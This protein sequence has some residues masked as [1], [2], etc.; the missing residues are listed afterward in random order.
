MGKACLMSLARSQ[1]G[2]R[3]CRVSEMIGPLY[4]PDDVQQWSPGVEIGNT[5]GPS[6]TGFSNGPYSKSQELR[7]GGWQTPVTDWVCCCR[8]VSVHSLWGFPNL[9]AGDLTWAVSAKQASSPWMEF[10]L[11]FRLLNLTKHGGPR[12]INYLC[13]KPK[14]SPWTTN[15]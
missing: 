7:G 10:L 4:L 13:K 8:Q 12:N 14:Q 6:H 2:L 15:Q 3:V 9:T 5:V 1:G 11:S